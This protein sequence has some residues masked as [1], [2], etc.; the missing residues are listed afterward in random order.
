MSLPRDASDGTAAAQTRGVASNP[1]RARLA[2]EKRGC[3]SSGASSGACPAR[4]IPSALY[5]PSR[6]LITTKPGG[7]PSRARDHCRPR[8]WPK[9]TRPKL[10]ALLWRC[11]E[12]ARA[13]YA[14]GTSISRYNLGV[15][16]AHMTRN[17]SSARHTGFRCVTVAVRG[18]ETGRRRRAPSFVEPFERVPSEDSLDGHSFKV[19]AASQAHSFHKKT[20]CWGIQQ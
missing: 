16:L 13:P 15:F 7:E 6:M 4:R 8:K 3:M 18:G 11:Y 19:A 10:R 9:Q 2:N 12:G 14:I 17:R 5:T 1:A 20:F